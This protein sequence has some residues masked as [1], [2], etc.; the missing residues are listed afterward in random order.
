LV[1]KLF[2]KLWGQ[3]EKGQIASADKMEME[4]RAEIRDPSIGD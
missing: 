1:G 2:E 4:Q 3:M